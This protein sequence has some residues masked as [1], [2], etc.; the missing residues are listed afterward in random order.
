MTT[1]VAAEF[2]DSISRRTFAAF[3]YIETS[4]SCR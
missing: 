4:I 2:Y 3:A 1:N